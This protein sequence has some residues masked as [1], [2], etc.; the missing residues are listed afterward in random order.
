MTKPLRLF[1]PGSASD[2][3]TARV[4]RRR[5]VTGSGAALA[6][7]GLGAIAA[8]T[9]ELTGPDA[10]LAQEATPAA[11]SPEAA[12][13]QGADH[14]AAIAFFNPDEA[15][16]VEALTARIMPGTVDDPGAREAGV[17]SYI[18]R[19]LAGPNLGVRLKTYSQGPFLQVTEEPASVEATSAPDLYRIPVTSENV[20][21]YGYQSIMTPQ[22]MY[23]RG[24]AAVDA[25]AQSQFEANFVELTEEQQ[26]AILT[27]MADDSATGFDG[28]SAAAFFTQLRN[29]TIEGF[30]S[31][32]LYGGNRDLVGWQLIGYPGAQAYYLP[33]ELTDE[34]FSREP[35]SLTQLLEI[36]GH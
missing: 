27:D 36:A 2:G 14:E 10:A 5:L 33:E 24:L 3:P 4:S 26:D 21:R 20:A 32:P 18:D 28:P 13:A 1:P 11:A 19:A 23:W 7:T 31:D 9:H 6:T 34:S 12:V 29:D 25:Y 35:Q 16:L 15:R 17:V 8:A 22:E 30:F